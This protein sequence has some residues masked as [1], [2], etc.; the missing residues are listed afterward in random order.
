MVVSEAERLADEVIERLRNLQDYLYA[1]KEDSL[2]TPGCSI[3]Y[4]SKIEETISWLR[5]I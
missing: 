3:E 5:N 4:V 1:H 2:P